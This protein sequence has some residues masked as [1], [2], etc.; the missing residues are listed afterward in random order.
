MSNSMC[1]PLTIPTTPATFAFDLIFNAAQ[2][3]LLTTSF[4]E[5]LPPPMTAFEKTPLNWLN[6]DIP[7]WKTKSSTIF[8]ITND[9][10]DHV[11]H[12]LEQAIH[13]FN[14]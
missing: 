12:A 5:H 3:A 14:T 10:H 2:N 13:E 11:L 6:P 1:P 8:T 4:Y 7:D 9:K